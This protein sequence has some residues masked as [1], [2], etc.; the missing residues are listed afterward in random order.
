MRS[1]NDP[2]I[3]WPATY[4]SA[5]APSA[6]AA[7]SAPNPVPTA[8]GTKAWRTPSSNAPI[9]AAPATSAQKRRVR[10]VRRTLARLATAPP[11]PA[12]RGSNPAETAPG[13]DV[14]WRPVARAD[15]SASTARVRPAGPRAG[16]TMAGP[17]VIS[18]TKTTPASD[19]ARKASDAERQPAVSM[20]PAA[21]GRATA[22]PMPGPA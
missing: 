7:K 17:L 1:V 8:C 16:T 15:S 13:A 3:T 18:Q 21:I 22:T 5:W 12:G 19:A 2:P 14:S 9:A 20:S 4:A 11:L 10:I 6:L